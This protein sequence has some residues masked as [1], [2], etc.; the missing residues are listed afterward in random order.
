PS[1]FMPSPNRTFCS[2][3]ATSFLAGEP[4][5]E[6]IVSRA[7]KMMGKRWRWLRPLARR[8]LKR[9]ARQIRPRHGDVVQFLLRDEGF[10]KAYARHFKAVNI[11]HWLTRPRRMQPVK[12]AAGWDVPV[13]ESVGELAGWLGLTSSELE[14]FADLKGLERRKDGPR[15]RH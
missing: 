1:V 6:Q 2:M 11:K 4:A 8:Y 13:I 12:A 14:W 10:R 9:F 5:I 7:S 15:L 3:L